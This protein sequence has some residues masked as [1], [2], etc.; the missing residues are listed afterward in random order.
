M[1]SIQN[2]YPNLDKVLRA[3]PMTVVDA[4]CAGGIDPMFSDLA[5]QGYAD[6]IGFE[7]NPKE[8]EKLSHVQSSPGSRTVIHN[9]A[10]GDREGVIT[11][12]ACGSVGSIHSRPDREALYGETY[13]SLQVDCASL[14]TLRS[15]G[16]IPR[17]IDVLK[18][19]VEGS[20]LAVLVGAAKALANEVLCIKVEFGFHSAMGT[21]NFGELHVKLV[22]AGFRLLGLTINNSSMTGLDAGDALY[23]RRPEVVLRM[24]GLSSEEKR[25]KLVHLAAICLVLRQGEYLALITR[26]GDELLPAHEKAELM[27]LAIGECFVPNVVSFSFPRLS[28]AVFALSQLVAGRKHGSKSAPKVN[29]LVQLRIL[30][31][32]PRWKWMRRRHEEQLGRKVESYLT[33]A[34]LET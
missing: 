20:E 29:R 3:N 23:V 5:K 2:N 12:N 30:F 21:N 13:E 26:I 28:Q 9:M 33:R 31:A 17:S 1:L 15:N 11:F 24:P 14:D 32:R 7:A 34:S 22:T 4:G 6:N 27:G 19:D 25:V 10:L 18:L 16:T 8:F